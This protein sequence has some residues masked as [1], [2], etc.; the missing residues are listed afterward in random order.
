MLSVLEGREV[1]YLDRE[2]GSRTI[3]MVAGV[4][5]RSPLHSNASGKVLLAHQAE[6]FVAGYLDGPLERFTASTI[7]EREQL[8]CHLGAVVADGYATCWQE[9]ESELCSVSVPIFDFTGTVVAALTIAGP[10]SRIAPD[11]YEHLLPPLRERAGEISAGLGA[12]DLPGRP[13]APASE[14]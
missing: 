13:A 2:E 11:R 9:H 7:V 4:G 12:V 1:F 3:R 8:R 5:H 6:S 14:R 10:V